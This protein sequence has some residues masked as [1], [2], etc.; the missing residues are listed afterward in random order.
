MQHLPPTF[1]PQQ[2]VD[3]LSLSPIASAIYITEDIN[4]AY[5]N[6]TMLGFWGKEEGVIGE[7]LGVAFPE[8]NSQPFI[9]IL[10]NVWHTGVAYEGKDIPAQL[11]RNGKLQTF[12][13]DFVY[14]PIKN[15]KGEVY[16]ILNTATDVT[17]RNLNKLALE[18]AKQHENDLKIEQVVNEELRKAKENLSKLNKEL[19]ARVNYRTKELSDSEATLR[20]LIAQAPVAIAVLKGKDLIIASANAKVL[21]TWGKTE[22]II[23]I[24]LRTAF[25]EIKDHFL[26]SVLDS[27][28]KY[29]E[30]YY[31]NEI[32]IALNDEET[33][34]NIVYQPIKNPKGK[35]VSIM[36][37]ANVI[38]EQV[39]ARKRAEDAEEMLRFSIEAANVGTWFLNIQTRE[40]VTSPRF[41]E[42]YGFNT[43]DKFSYLDILAL[44][45]NDYHEK[46]NDE[47]ENTLRTG[48]R[49][50][51]EHP[52]I[53]KKDNKVRW[54]KSL[55]KLYTDSSNR[56]LY[57]SGI[58]LDTTEQKLDDLRKNDFIGMVSH[59]LK[60]PLTTLKGYV[61][62]LNARAIKEN[63]PFGINALNKVEAQ[64]NKMSEL[65]RS[66]LDVS[67][68]ES[69]KINLTKKHF[70]L[71]ELITEIIE[72][73]IFTVPDQ[74]ILFENKKDVEVYAD[75]EKIGA[76]ISNLLSNAIKY[77]PKGKKIIFNCKLI[78]G[79]AQV[80]VKDEGI[81]INQNDLTKLFDRYYRVENAQTQHISGFGIGLYLSAEIIKQHN[82]KIWV[83]SEIEK[84]ATFYFSIPVNE[85]VIN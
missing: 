23:G 4:V 64:I 42:L 20:N 54:V 84:G 63:D 28:Y 85:N 61:Q 17:E 59:E 78:N 82:G 49:Y 35:T 13:Y 57:F 47:F 3:I 8:L 80:S 14:N 7:S 32:R 16:C 73:N 51:M 10:K 9:Q 69:G 12:Y 76:V 50:T 5:A 79:Y 37:V 21:E 46:I 1:T 58:M 67:R 22:E 60:T 33:F 30:P 48:N 27:V 44:V 29:G 66:F 77:S 72:E 34:A 68:F 26:F 52:I 24:S 74:I 65:I 25:A 83:V 15:E 62:L 56:A 41:K 38:T 2:L 36:L 81:G 45:P 43:D 75:S 18:K 40:M 11:M 70:L 53:S 31:G 39:I 55:G 19:E 71:N 6:Q